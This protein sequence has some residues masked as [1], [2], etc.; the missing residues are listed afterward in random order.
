M[1]GIFPHDRL[2]QLILVEDDPSPTGYGT[3]PL[4]RPKLEDLWDIPIPLKE[5]LVTDK[6]YANLAT[7]LLRSPSTKILFLGG[8]VM[9]CSWLREGGALA[10]SGSV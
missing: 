9:V 3:R 10:A 5:V 6:V 7:A 8:D 1:L 2:S 4:T